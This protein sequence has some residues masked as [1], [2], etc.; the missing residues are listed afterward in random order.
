MWLLAETDL[1][2]V[3]EIIYLP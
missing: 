3:S 2:K 1:H